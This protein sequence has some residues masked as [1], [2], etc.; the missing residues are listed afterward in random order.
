MENDP[1]RTPPLSVEF[2]TLFWWV[3]L[4]I[5]D[6]SGALL[7]PLVFIIIP[8]TPLPRFSRVFNICLN[9]L[10]SQI[11]SDCSQQLHTQ[12]DPWQGSG[13]LLQDHPPGQEVDTED[14]HIFTRFKLWTVGTIINLISAF[15]SL[16]YIRI[17]LINKYVRIVDHTGMF[18]CWKTFSPWVYSAAVSSSPRTCGPITDQYW[19]QY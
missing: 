12:E 16:T 18:L 3:P 4:T 6:A 1:V 2:A 9:I 11:C 14:R 15:Y 13:C 19:D 7:P 17:N 10:I 5:N 8:P